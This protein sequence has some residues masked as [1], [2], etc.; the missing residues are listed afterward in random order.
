MN[1]PQ[2]TTTKYQGLEGEDPTAPFWASGNYVGPYWSDGKVQTSVEWGDKQP[3]NELDALA[4]QHDAAYAHFKDSAHREAADAIFAE[5]AR[6]LK[7]K[8]GKKLADNPKF[9]A[10]MVEYGN[11]T[12][13]QAKKLASSGMFVPGLAPLAVM[14]YGY[15]HVKEFTARIKGTHLKNEKLD[16]RD[17]YGKDTN[18]A[19]KLESAVANSSPWKTPTIDKKGNSSG[20][21]ALNEAAG[22]AIAAINP[23]AGKKKNS[24]TPASF[25]SLEK[26]SNSDHL[27]RSQ[28]ARFANYRALHDAA[29]A[30]NKG[31]VPVY[32]K[33]RL[34]MNKAKPKKTKRKRIAVRPL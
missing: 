24:V 7:Q 11:H 5:E 21:M 3:V 16:V 29:L 9:A 2:P 1:T 30:S 32:H 20:R 12:V 31:L 13:R 22:Y 8:Y 19:N 33:P 4:R 18:A 27:V 15:D 14:K 6:K 25:S 34:N 28:A 17:F 23:A 26:N 10:A